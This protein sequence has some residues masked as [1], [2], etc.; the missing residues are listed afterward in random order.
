MTW[1]VV[2]EL[3]EGPTI[4]I[5]GLDPTIFFI[6]IICNLID[7]RARPLVRIAQKR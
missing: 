7:Y 5:V 6:F 1:G 4:V 2:P 3:V